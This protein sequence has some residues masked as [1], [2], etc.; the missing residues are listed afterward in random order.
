MRRASVEGTADTPPSASITLN[1]QNGKRSSERSNRTQWV[2]R[3]E[4]AACT[5]R[6]RGSACFPARAP[7]EAATHLRMNERA[8]KQHITVSLEG[9]NNNQLCKAA[10]H[11]KLHAF[12]A[13]KACTLASCEAGPTGWREAVGLG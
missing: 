6:H 11:V 4:G 1:A 7:L 13:V 8:V 5:L 12:I 2:R 9:S 3:R 10:R